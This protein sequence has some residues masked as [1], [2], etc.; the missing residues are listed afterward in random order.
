M[1]TPFD[2]TDCAKLNYADTN[3]RAAMIDAMKYWVTN[4]DIDGFRCDV[5][6]EVPV[7]FWEQ[8]RLDLEKT[9]PMFMPVSY[10]HL[11]VYKRQGLAHEALLQF[12]IYC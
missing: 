8:A 1:M 4:C 12:Y 11:D 10:T 2:W 5:A 3:M 7:D 6:G 9:K